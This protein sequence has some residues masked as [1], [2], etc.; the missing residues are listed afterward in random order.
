MQPMAADRG[1]SVANIALAWLLHQE[2]VTS[3][4]I[5]AKTMDQLED[6]LKAVNVE[7]SA[8]ELAQLDDVSALPREYPQWMIE[9]QAAGR[10]PDEPV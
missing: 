4:L 7:L 2:W 3:V 8:Q 6:N 5:G 10:A 9:R 1:V